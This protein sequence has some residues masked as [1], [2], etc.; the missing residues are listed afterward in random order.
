MNLTYQLSACHART[1]FRS[2]IDLITYLPD[3][4]QVPQRGCLNLQKT[5]E[6]RLALEFRAV[7]LS[8]NTYSRCSM[9]SSRTTIWLL[10]QARGILQPHLRC[11]PNPQQGSEMCLAPLL[12]PMSTSSD[13]YACWFIR[14]YPA[15]VVLFIHL[16]VFLQHA[17]CTHPISHY[18]L[19]SHL[20]PSSHLKFLTSYTR[21]RY[22]TRPS[23]PPSHPQMLPGDLPRPAS[24]SRTT[25]AC[26]IQEIYEA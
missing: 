13:A 15:I 21:S 22:P 3:A 4:V 7:C 1:I 19:E 14:V 12:Y 25:S 6:I 23:A 9:K 2:H 20:A 18:H 10:I 24:A 5:C 8:P 17:L 11:H 16:P 26:V